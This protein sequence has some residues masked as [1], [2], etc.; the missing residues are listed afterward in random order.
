M[1]RIKGVHILLG[2]LIFLLLVSFFVFHFNPF[3][4]VN[5]FIQNKI[6]NPKSPPHDIRDNNYSNLLQMTMMTLDDDPLVYYKH[7]KKLVREACVAIEKHKDNSPEALFITSVQLIRENEFAESFDLLYEIVDKYPNWCEAY[8]YLGYIGFKYDITP[9][10]RSIEHLK[11]AIKCNP[12][13]ARYY[14]FLATVYRHKYKDSQDNQYLNL[15]KENFELALKLDPEDLNAYNNYANFLVEIG[16]YEKAEQCYKKAM[17]IY[18]EHGKPYYNLACLKAL[19]GDKVSAIKY[20]TEALNKNPDFRYDAKNDPDLEI[21][22]NDPDFIELIYNYH[23][24]TP[25]NLE[26]IEQNSI[27]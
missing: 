13:K 18:P 25:L 16:D 27:E 20:L 21:L 12:Q 23:G 15:A 1:S 3:C 24:D 26:K 8:C 6:C 19:Q 7:T 14:S 22:K 11:K 2:L 5:E 9:L 4:I 17:S 10:D